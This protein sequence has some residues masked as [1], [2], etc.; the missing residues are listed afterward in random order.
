MED[1]EPAPKA[2]RPRKA[3]AAKAGKATPAKTAK[4]TKAAK[5]QPAKAAPEATP[6][7]A[8]KAA[9]TT[10]TPRPAR[11]TA[12]AT[13]TRTPTATTAL[14]DPPEL[15]VIVPA[16]TAP[17]AA[18]AVALTPVPEAVTLAPVPVRS[19]T[20]ERPLPVH[21]ALGAQ[22]REWVDRVRERYPQAGA[23]ALARLATAEFGRA[24]RRH[25]AATSAAGVLGSVGA[26]GVIAQEQARLVLAIAYV[27]GFDPTAPERADELLDLL[28]LPRRA[29]GT[30][31]A[32]TNV[33]RL[34]AGVATRRA[35]AFLVPFG[36][37]AAGAVQG[38]RGCE[39]VA[40]RAVAYYRRAV[41]T[42]AR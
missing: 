32:L 4:A 24:A 39:E 19:V 41:E 18:E 17:P 25:G 13:A 33:G 16:P 1:S 12:A 31:A 15:P 11:R 37:A 42:G 27:Y 7:A 14:P 29:Q 28:R 36:A 22:T 2:P 30:R 9:K 3:A 35:A 8:T 20:A 23:E 6:P 26:T 10:A 38:A 40:R 21:Q 34:V 5:A